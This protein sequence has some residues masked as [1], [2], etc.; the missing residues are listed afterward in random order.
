MEGVGEREFNSTAPGVAGGWADD[1]LRDAFG[2]GMNNPP[3]PPPPP[4][5]TPTHV[6]SPAKQKNF[7]PLLVLNIIPVVIIAV[8]LYLW[9]RPEGLRKDGQTTAANGN[10]VEELE[11]K[12]KLPAENGATTSRPDGGRPIVTALGPGVVTTPPQS[13]VI[14]APP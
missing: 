5:P 3:P 2:F 10:T 9:L 1:D 13:R 6:P 12:P 4:T 14:T 7:K 11:G 8:F